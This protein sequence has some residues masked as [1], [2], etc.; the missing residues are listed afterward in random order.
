MEKE[1][2]TIIEYEKELLEQEQEH[3]ELEDL[4]ARA[5]KRHATQKEERLRKRVRYAVCFALVLL[6]ALLFTYLFMKINAMDERIDRIAHALG[7]GEA[8]STEDSTVADWTATALADDN[9]APQKS[10]MTDIVY[11]AQTR[12]EEEYEE[13]LEKQE[14][15]LRANYNGHK[16]YLTFDD[17]PSVYTP[18][19]L[20]TLK[21]NNV[22]ATFFV[23]YNG[24]QSMWPLYN[25]IVDEGHSI[26]LHSYTHKYEIVYANQECFERDVKSIHD[27][28]EQRTGV[29]SRLYRFPGGS[30]NTV[31]DHVD[32][33]EMI[34]YLDEEGYTYF[35]WNAQSGDAEDDSLTAEEL[36][37]NVM[38]YVRANEGDSVVLM[39]D[40]KNCQETAKA[41]QGLID[42]LKAEGYEICPI[43]E[44]VIPVQH[45][46]ED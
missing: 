1:Q 42:T 28:V 13:Y 6:P 4:E 34:D 46:T 30:S 21:K 5:Q 25:R 14:E 37:E 7:V 36:N 26:G 17:G 29:D 39:H 3:R 11:L 22:K 44:D 8:V 38:G 15:E 43:T 35:D 40:F 24:D 33:Q 10:T 23:I 9:P 31:S 16:V 27:F 12:S 19:I 45:V 18:M 41:L 2:K 32:T 20:D